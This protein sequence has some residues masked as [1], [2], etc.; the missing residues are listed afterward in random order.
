MILAVNTDRFY[1][2]LP[3][4]EHFIDVTVSENFVAVPE[5]WYIVVTDVVQ[6]T[7]A[8]AAGGYK[9][10]NFIGAVTIVSLLNLA[11]N[12]D[13]PFVFGGDGSSLLIPGYLLIPAKQALLANRDLARRDFQLDLRVGI[14]PV[15][16]VTID[17]ELRIAKLRVSENY[18]QAVFRGG[19][20]TYATQLLKN[21]A[22]SGL[23]Q[24]VAEDLMPQANL[25]GLE[26]RWQ[27]IPSPHG[28]MV[29]LMVLA[30]APSE[31]QLN[32][33]YR[34]VILQLEK[35][36]GGDARLNPILPASLCLSFS[37]KNLDLEAKA[38]A[39]GRRWWNRQGY[40]LKM[41]W[42]NALGWLLMGLGIR[43]PDVDWGAYKQIVTDATDYRKFDDMLRMVISST[44]AQRR[45][46]D[47][48]LE[49]KYQEGRLVYGIHTSASAL[50]T[51]LVFER[52]GQQVHFVDGGDGG[53]AL[54]AV[55]MKRRMMA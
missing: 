2:Q 7:Q 1:E 9:S 19:G 42:E 40:L 37:Q 34:D 27:D 4:L 6:S 45:K 48:Y 33:I 31:N 51:C 21:L 3:A 13:I 49:K 15:S 38:R 43:M 54:A 32:R 26:C 35:I 17:Y 53:Y 30:T 16:A 29:T 55:A 11:G 14:I 46:L 10:V 18:S 22:T 12:L 25:S 47:H 28:E 39:P 41:R 52:G 50:M 36:Y 8:I 24:L 23:Y 44:P 5:D 20:L